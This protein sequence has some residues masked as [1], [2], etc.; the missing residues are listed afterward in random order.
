MRGI[1]ALPA[2]VIASLCGPG[3]L[4]AQDRHWTAPRKTTI[5]LTAQAPVLDGRLDD[6]AWTNASRLTNF[7]DLKRLKRTVA[8]QT[9]VWIMRDSQRL[10]AA[11]ACESHDPAAIRADTPREARDSPRL[12]EEDTVSLLLDPER[13]QNDCYQWTVNA[14][15]AILDQVLHRLVYTERMVPSPEW[16]SRAEAAGAR[17]DGRWCVELAIPFSDIP[18]RDRN[19]VAADTAWGFQAARQNRTPSDPTESASAWSSTFRVE[20]P[21]SF[22][23]ASFTG[24]PVNEIRQAWVQTIDPVSGRMDPPQRPDYRFLRSFDFGPVPDAAERAADDPRGVRHV[25][26]DSGFEDG[27]GYGFEATNG[28][29]GRRSPNRQF[30][31]GGRLSP[32]SSDYLVSATAAVFRFELPAGDYRAAFLCGKNMLLGDVAGMDFEIDVNGS[33]VR[34]WHQ[35]AGRVF[36]P[37]WVAFRSD[38]REPVAVRLTPAPGT[39]WALSGFVVAPADEEPEAREAFYWLERDCYQYPFD[40]LVRGVEAWID[41]SGSPIRPLLLPREEK[42]GLAVFARSASAFTPASA[43]PEETDA[44]DKATVIVSPGYRAGF[45][46]GV[47]ARRPLTRLRAE[48]ERMPG[49]GMRMC[50]WQTMDSVVH[51]GKLAMNQMAFFPRLLARVEPVWLKAGR[52]QAYFVSVEADPGAAPGIRRGTVGLYDGDRR[53]ARFPYELLV[54]P[55]TPSNRNGS[56]RSVFFNPPLCGNFAAGRT[57]RELEDVAVK[58]WHQVLDLKRHGLNA[59]H[60]YADAAAYR[61]EADGLWHF[62]PR[63]QEYRFWAMLQQAGIREH[64]VTIPIIEGQFGSAM[65][66]D[67][68]E[69]AGHPERVAS[70]STRYRCKD[71][72]PPAFFENVALLVR[73]NL[74]ARKKGGYSLPAF[75]PWDEPGHLNSE[76]LVPI[77]EAIRAGGGKTCVQTIAACFPTL[78]GKVDVRTY[79]MGSLA[80]AGGEAETPER[81]LELKRRE[82]CLVSVYPNTVIMGGDPRAARQMYGAFAWAWNLDAVDP[83]KYWKILGDYRLSAGEQAGSFHPVLF[84]AEG[85]AVLTTASWENFAEGIYEH[86]LIQELTFCLGRPAPGVEPAAV[87]E[88]AAFLDGLRR[89]S[90]FHPSFVA[91]GHDGL[92]GAPKFSRFN[93][94]PLRFDRQRAELA[95]HLLR[96]SGVER[97]P[98]RRVC[99]AVAAEAQGLRS[100]KSG[101]APSSGRGRRRRGR[102]T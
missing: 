65:I 50:L 15:G 83:Y 88:A 44:R 16:S 19:A 11:F 6:A 1:P 48:L 86:D 31:G 101:F 75:D 69:R 100:G 18:S 91:R 53:L 43:L 92:T 41:I 89:D 87:A 9:T 56:I 17:G 62:R 51:V 57:G 33:R 90:A 80:V 64:V 47:H 12:H 32:L 81:V 66:N 20:E 13:S 36:L 52:T 4:L 37:V 78:S 42:R 74:E 72:L 23:V 40:K 27:P 84:D 49:D 58:T 96:L 5:P 73:E 82:G 34:C 70:M 29:A 67:Y 8:E 14:Q 95:F 7:L 68:L 3:F 35:E 10:Y 24:A 39:Q 97:G 46:I 54:L 63:D 77:L 102:A 21:D 22:G 55:V 76:A 79:D 26:P 85:D 99:R 25:A 38:G 93:W 98:H 59:V 2:M 60:V 71:K 61:K 30:G 45:T 94:H 28:L